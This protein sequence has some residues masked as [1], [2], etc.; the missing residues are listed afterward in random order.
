VSR[1]DRRV[2]KSAPSG[3]PGESRTA[4][5][6]T[7][8]WTLC[9]LATLVAEAGALLS[10]AYLV[11]F[12]GPL[13]LQVLSGVLLFVALVAGLVTLAL[14]PMTWRLRRVPPPRAIVVVA[15]AAGLMPL[16]AVVA[17]VIRSL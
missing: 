6:V 13:W 15:V 11:L 14:T 7:V 16:V 10:R 17:R 1:R 4:E 9:L 8:A 12:S 3:R 5:A 2:R